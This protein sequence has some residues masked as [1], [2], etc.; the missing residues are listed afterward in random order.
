MVVYHRFVNFLLIQ[1][2]LLLILM[3][4]TVLADYSPKN[5]FVGMK[6]TIYL[7]NTE[8]ASTT[9]SFRENMSLLIDAYDGFGLYLPINNIFIAL[10]WVPN[11]HDNDDLFMIVNGVVVSEFIVGWGVTLP[12]YRFKSIFLFFGYEE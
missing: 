10:Y 7:Y 9:I 6:Y 3:P 12:N 5:T 4:T 1:L 11:Y 2:F 8:E